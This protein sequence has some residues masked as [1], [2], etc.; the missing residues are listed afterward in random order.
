MHSVDAHEATTQ[1]PGLL[2]Q[3][4]AT[5]EAITITRHGLPVALLTPVPDTRGRDLSTVIAALREL[6]HEVALSG[7]SVQE[8]IGEGRR[9]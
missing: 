2:E 3:V 8:M 4:M 9:H 7:L 5:G 1:L 6:R